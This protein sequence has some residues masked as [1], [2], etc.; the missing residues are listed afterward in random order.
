[1]SERATQ[2]LQ[3]ANRQI[4][5]LSALLSSTDQ[6]GLGSPCPGREK[7]GDGTVAAV[8]LHTTDTYLRIAGFVRGHG[9]ATHPGAAVHEEGY[10]AEHADTSGL[11]ERL[12]NGRQALTALAGLTDEQLDAVPPTGQA[13]FC[14]GKRTLEEVLTSMLKH[15]GHQIDALRAAI[16]R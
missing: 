2:L 7:L 3:A 1:M 8:A 11:M 9:E 16:A 13:R 10:P 5:E 4:T 14:D 6:A 12:A 15:Q